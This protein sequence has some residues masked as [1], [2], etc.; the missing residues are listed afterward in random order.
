MLRT[1]VTSTN[2]T[3]FWV[4][5]FAILRLIS[6][7][8]S[9]QPAVVIAPPLLHPRLVPVGAVGD[10]VGG[11]GVEQVVVQPQAVRGAAGRPELEQRLEGRQGLQGPVKLI[12]RGTTSCLAAAWAITVRIRL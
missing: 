8:G 6:A 10:P 1:S 9:G 4:T 3:Y 7:R 11:D 12:D 2:G 5:R